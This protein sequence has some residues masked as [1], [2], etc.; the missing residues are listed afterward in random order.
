MPSCASTPEMPGPGTG[1]ATEALLARARTLYARGDD[2]AARDAYLELLRLEPTHF[3]ALN[4]LGTMAY[5][6]GHRA[7][8]RTAYTQAARLHPDNPIGRVNLG[9][10]LLEEDAPEEARAQFE[11]A[12]ACDGECIEAHRGFARALSV[13]GDEETAAPHWHKGYSGEAAIAVQPYRGT[14]EAISVLLLVSARGGNIPTQ[15]FLDDTHFAVTALYTDYFDPGRPL[16]PHGV[17]FNAIGDADLCEAALARAERIAAATSAPIINPPDI[18]RG[19]TRAGV[20]QRLAGLAGVK[21]PA[22]RQATREALS[23]HGDLAFPLLLRAPGFHTGRHFVR[24]ERREDMADA[25][26]RLPGEVLLAIE[27]LDAR[28]ADGLARKYRVMVIDRVLYPLH[29]AI[30][31]DWKVHYFT[32]DMAQSQSHRREEQRFLEDMEGALGA[33]AVTA[34]RRI[35]ETLRLDYGG[36]DFGLAPNGSVLLFEANATMVINPPDSNPIWEYRRAPIARA[37][38]AAAAMVR[39]RAKSVHGA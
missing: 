9:N 35:A 13:L 32:A 30:A 36:I 26:A 24:V 17:V 14:G 37:R 38:D 11:A 16:P 15:R 1:E 25:M 6:G 33:R 18:I 5:A 28:G 21:A 19:T 27:Y 3:S 23:G 2:A 22:I 10:L 20:A 12:L 4:E 29:L 39:G 7:A 34:L 31:R 8:A